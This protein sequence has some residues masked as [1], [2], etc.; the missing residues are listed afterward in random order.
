VAD[1]IQKNTTTD[2]IIKIA[3]HSLLV[4]T[5]ALTT[6]SAPLWCVQ[7]TCWEQPV[8]WHVTWGHLRCHK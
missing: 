5:S 3:H 7:H 2:I 6:F 1:A 4:S 8:A